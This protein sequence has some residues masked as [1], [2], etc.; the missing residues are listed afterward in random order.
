[1]HS[2]NNIDHIVL[3]E[4]LDNGQMVDN[5]WDIMILR[6]AAGTHDGVAPQCSHAES[7]QMIAEL[8]QED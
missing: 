3:R 5:I 1:M 6:H 4:G 7:V 8:K 2:D